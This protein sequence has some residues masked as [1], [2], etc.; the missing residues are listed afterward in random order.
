MKKMYLLLV[1]FTII[2]LFSCSKTDKESISQPV[3]EETPVEE[4][5]LPETGEVSVIYVEGNVYYKQDENW[6]PVFIGDILTLGDEIKTEDGIC[7][8]QFGE[9]A[10]VRLDYNTVVAME[11]LVGSG[12]DM[13]ARVGVSEGSL[14]AKVEKLVGNERFKVRTPTTT[15]GVRGTAF[16]VKTDKEGKTQLAVKE[17]AVRVIPAPI[18]MDVVKDKAEIAGEEMVALV[19]EIEDNAPLVLPDQEIKI[20]PE[21]AK[22]TAEVIAKVKAVVNSEAIKKANDN[23]EKKEILD[24]IEKQDM[25]LVEP[26]EPVKAVESAVS[27]NI[28]V[29]RDEIKKSSVYFASV[30]ED[31]NPISDEH[32]EALEAADEMKVY[33]AVEIEKEQKKPVA[34]LLE[35][36]PRDSE[37]IINGIGKISGGKFQ[38]LFDP[39]TS[40]SVSIRR[41]GYIGQTLDIDLP[42]SGGKSIKVKLKK[43]EKPLMDI[44]LKAEPSDAR[45]FINNKNV[46]QGEY[47]SKIKKG[48]KLSVRIEKEGYRTE[49]LQLD[50][51]NNISKKIVLVPEEKS[52]SIR[53]TVEPTEAEI[54]I[55]D[56]LVGKGFAEIS[57]KKGDSLNIEVKANGYQPERLSL[58]LADNLPA[59]KKIVLKKQRESIKVKVS[60]EDA[61]IFLGKREVGTG[62]ADIKPD[63]NNIELIVKRPGYAPHA[64]NLSETQEDIINVVLT[65]RPL[66]ASKQIP[67]AKTFVRSIVGNRGTIIG[68]DKTGTIWAV[69]SEGRLLWS[70]PTKNNNNENILPVINKD[71][72]YVSGPKEF[73]ILDIISGAP[74]YRQDLTGKA[75]HIFGRHIVADE[76]I[77]LYPEDDRLLVLNA[78]TGQKHREISLPESSRM[79]PAIINGYAYIVTERGK[80]LKISLKDNNIESV[81]TSL[82]QPV[83]ISPVVKGDSL[84]VI[85]RRGTLMSLDTKSL[86]LSWKNKITGDLSS[87]TEP[88]VG[89]KIYIF[90]EHKIYAVS[91][92]DGKVSYTIS[93]AAASP[94]ITGSLLVYPSED[95]KLKLCEQSSGATLA[96]LYM[97]EAASAAP[98]ARGEWIY[99]PTASGKIYIYNIAHYLK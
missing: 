81:D 7:E 73:V 5:S 17:G 71:R 58:E 63:S 59:E 98:H 18:D 48:E 50:V 31:I 72:V 14:V 84:Y 11:R 44:M 12:G 82:V 60:P 53:L 56:E 21:E 22:Q 26:A 91:P 93:G 52:L 55:G 9:R 96:E 97:G 36:E 28:S 92:A 19:A 70:F 87:F 54:Y 45:I 38:K 88:V 99:V 78:S 29:S 75:A 57:G 32:K 35:V 61:K 62:E 2:L 1:I 25:E 64:F 80:L 49:T 6:E 40:L 94:A 39:G 34:F 23:P 90:N 95:G 47:T 67:G 27:E 41:E 65:P 68:V 43:E 66:V 20:E 13:D 76:N 85:D 42:D 37:I 86:S 89:E 4:I 3:V 33:A 8:L 46:A 51:S 15:C 10:V 69:S 74:V 79:S 83:A 30:K 77:L 24:K 16:R